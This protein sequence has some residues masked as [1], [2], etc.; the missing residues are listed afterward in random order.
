MTPTRLKVHNPG[1]GARRLYKRARTVLCPDPDAGDAESLDGLLPQGGAAGGGPL[2]TATATG[3]A[4][5]A[6]PPVNPLD[7]LEQP[8]LDV[9]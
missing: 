3:V 2:A 8:V 1:D 9:V 7:E 5:Y 6:P 4:S